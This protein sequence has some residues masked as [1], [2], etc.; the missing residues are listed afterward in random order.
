MAGVFA[1]IDFFVWEV[2]SGEE[3]AT[4]QGSNVV[5]NLYR[6]TAKLHYS[7]YLFFVGMHCDI[8]VEITHVV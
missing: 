7:A 3:I 2:G 8:F 5:L 6:S 1:F 4:Q